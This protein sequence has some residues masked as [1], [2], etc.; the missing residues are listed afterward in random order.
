MKTNHYPVENMVVKKPYATGNYRCFYHHYRWTDGQPISKTYTTPSG[1]TP[2][3]SEDP[4]NTLNITDF[5]K[6]YD[7]SAEQI[8]KKEFTYTIIVEKDGVRKTIKGINPS[9]QW[10]RS[11]PN[12]P[13]YTITAVLDGKTTTEEELKKQGLAGKIGL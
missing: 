1:H 8:K 11:D 4:A 3:P 9:P 13:T 6:Y 10:Y 7:L 2:L 12:K 5:K